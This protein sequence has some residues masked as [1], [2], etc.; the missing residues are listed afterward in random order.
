M[1]LRPDAGLSLRD[2]LM[3]GDFGVFLAD[4]FFAEPEPTAD[5][6][7]VAYAFC[8]LAFFSTL[9]LLLADIVIR[10]IVFESETWSPLLLASDPGCGESTGLISL[11]ILFELVVW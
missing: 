1:V 8:P 3:C 7:V 11:V 10:A 5:E 2:E 9:L 4:R 6:G